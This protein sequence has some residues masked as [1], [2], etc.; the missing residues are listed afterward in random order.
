MLDEALGLAVAQDVEVQVLNMEGDRTHSRIFPN[1]PG[2]ENMSVG[3]V[4][5][6]WNLTCTL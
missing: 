4:G 3:V 1:V 6:S 5:C 2:D